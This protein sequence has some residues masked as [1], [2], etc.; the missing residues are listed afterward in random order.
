MNSLD[1]LPN[2]QK[3]RVMNAISVAVQ[4]SWVLHPPRHKTHAMLQERIDLCLC[5]LS[6]GLENGLSIFQI[7]DKMPDALFAYLNGDR[8]EARRASSWRVSDD[9]TE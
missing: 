2:T 5:W 1:N 4:N 7:C 9:R 3:L 6:M 8:P